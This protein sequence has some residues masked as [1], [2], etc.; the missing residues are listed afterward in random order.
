MFFHGFWMPITPLLRLLLHLRPRPVNLFAQKRGVMLPDKRHVFP[1]MR[2]TK[3]RRCKVCVCS[4][5]VNGARACY[6]NMLLVIVIGIDGHMVRYLFNMFSFFVH[7]SVRWHVNQGLCV[8]L[9]ANWAL[10][11]I[12]KEAIVIVFCWE[13]Y[14][15]QRDWR[16]WILLLMLQLVHLHSPINYWW[17]WWI[18]RSI[19]CNCPFWKSSWNN[20]ACT[21]VFCSCSLAFLHIVH[22][23]SWKHSTGWGPLSLWVFCLDFESCLVN[24]GSCL[25][26][27]KPLYVRF[28]FKYST[29]ASAGYY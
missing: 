24:R 15:D 11:N 19:K 26:A 27:G 28:A 9:L 10:N 21:F 17:R 14:D 20:S 22:V 13:L 18:P 2:R 29:Y 1:K 25:T 5:C 6:I 16:L 12:S 7:I 8:P 23:C 3:K 4:H